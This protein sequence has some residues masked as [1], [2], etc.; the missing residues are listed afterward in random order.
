MK[1][2]YSRYPTFRHNAKILYFILLGVLVLAGIF[3]YVNRYIYPFRA[4]YPQITATFSAPSTVDKSVNPEF[5]ITLNVSGQQI[6]AGDII[7]A[8]NPAQVEYYKDYAYASG[9]SNTDVATGQPFF[10]QPLLEQSTLATSPSPDIKL[11]TVLVSTYTNPNNPNWTT[12]ANIVFKFRAIGN[13]PATIK[14]DSTSKFAGLSGGNATFFD[15]PLTLPQSTITLTGATPSVTSSPIPTTTSGVTPTTGSSTPIPSTTPSSTPTRTPTPTLNP[16][17]DISLDLSVLFQGITDDPKDGTTKMQVDV[18]IKSTDGKVFMNKKQQF[19]AQGSGVWNS[20][21]DF[22]QV[23]ISK[24][25]VILIKGPKHLKKRFCDRDVSETT[26][27]TYNC[28]LGAISFNE[29]DNI[30]DF[31]NIV[32]LAG[33]IPSQNGIIDAVDITFIRQNFGKTDKATR[34]KGDL[35]LD[36]IVD[37]QD[38]ALILAALRFKYDEE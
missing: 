21:V 1:S 7:L 26:P 37:T 35:N 25:Y 23:D 28:S 9:V 33:D 10:N 32:L 4:A 27:G 14:L 2:S 31:T 36:G 16:K 8:Y 11:R 18:S 3:L 19:D 17:K 5:T 29:G 6:L 24:Q 22:K 15:L 12:N 20:V 13:G 38:Y 30:F 34:E